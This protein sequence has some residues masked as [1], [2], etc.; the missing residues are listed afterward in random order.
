MKFDDFFKTIV[1]T[2]LKWGNIPM[3]LGGP[4]IGKSS[5]VKW[6][7]GEI[8]TKSFSLACNQLGDLDEL[9][10]EGDFNV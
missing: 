7:A 8:G 2:D 3:L 6:F 1:E 10:K 4:G 9:K 5:W